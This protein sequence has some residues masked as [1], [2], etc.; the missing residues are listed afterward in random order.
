MIASTSTS[1]VTLIGTMPQPTLPL[2]QD[3][4][5][6]GGQFS[7]TPLDPQLQHRH[8]WKHLE[9]AAEIPVLQSHNRTMVD[10]TPFYPYPS[11]W[12]STLPEYQTYPNRQIGFDGYG[13]PMRTDLPYY[14]EYMPA[15]PLTVEGFNGEYQLHHMLYLVL[16]VVVAIIVIRMNQRK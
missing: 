11:Y 16:I 7:Y 8:M 1:P 6:R 15:W 2:Q 13:R 5:V 14:K 4:K 12:M 9:Y 10:L 3:A